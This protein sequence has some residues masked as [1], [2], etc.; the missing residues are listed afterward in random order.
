[1]KLDLFRA[2]DITWDSENKSSE[3]TTTIK[4]QEKLP[5]EIRVAAGYGT[6]DHYRIQARWQNNNWLGDGRQ[7]GFTLKYSSIP[8]SPTRCLSSH[9]SWCRACA[10]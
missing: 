6:D 9:I 5:R 4:V 3:V 10:A 2:V 7:L 8:A 1:M